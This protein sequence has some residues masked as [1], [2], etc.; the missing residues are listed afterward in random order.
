MF[1]LVQLVSTFSNLVHYK[2]RHSQSDGVYVDGTPPPLLYMSSKVIIRVVVV[3][4]AQPQ[5]LVVLTLVV[6]T[7]LLVIDFSFPA[8]MA[9]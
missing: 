1:N 8:Q 2:L 7:T 4:G 5:Q 6:I 3:A 9:D